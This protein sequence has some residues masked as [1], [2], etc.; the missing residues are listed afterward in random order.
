NSD[1]ESPRGALTCSPLH[2]TR[3]RRRLGSRSVNLF[4][5]AECAVR[6]GKAVLAGN[7]PQNAWARVPREPGRIARSL[8]ARMT[9]CMAR[10]RPSQAQMHFPSKEIGNPRDSVADELVVA[11]LVV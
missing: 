2:Q 7:W 4:G 8:T 11:S 9:I 3:Y 10:G 1:L 5:R 6:T